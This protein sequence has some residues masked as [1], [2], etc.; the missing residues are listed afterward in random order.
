MLEP[1]ADQLVTTSQGGA[2]TGSVSY[3]LGLLATA[4]GDWPQA[5]ARFTTAAGTHARIDAP[6]WL[7]RTRME[8]ARMLLLR[9]RPGANERARDLLGQALAT[10]RDLGLAKVERDSVALLQDCP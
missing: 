6:I 1:Y 8:H 3:Y 2:V 5:E 9:S 4:T 10:A 7:A